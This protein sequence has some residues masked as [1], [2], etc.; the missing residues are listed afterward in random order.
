MPG[1]LGAPGAAGIP[2]APGMPGI[3]GAAVA[4]HEGQVF[5]EGSTFAPHFGHS[6]GPE[7]TAAGLKHIVFSFLALLAGGGVG[8]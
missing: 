8:P 1:A 4:P 2:G 3:P 7:V 6:T 5:A